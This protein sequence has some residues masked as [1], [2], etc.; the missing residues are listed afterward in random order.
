M[1]SSNL[2]KKLY[3]KKFEERIEPTHLNKY[4]SFLILLLKKDFLQEK[5]VQLLELL[6]EQ[7]KTM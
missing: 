7:L 3:K 2:E 5:Q 1:T 6:S 4:R